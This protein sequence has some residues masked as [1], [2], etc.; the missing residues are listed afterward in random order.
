VHLNVGYF[1]FRDA[2]PSGV[3]VVFTGPIDRFFEYQCGVLGWRTLD[4]E[5]EV[6]NVPDFQGAPV[7]NY[8]DSDVPVTRTYE[9]SFSIRSETIRPSPP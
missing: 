8:A 7:M 2:I 4:F 6:L 5:Q 3:P 1:S 9:S